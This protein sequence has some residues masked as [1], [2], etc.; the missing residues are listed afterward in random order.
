MSSNKMVFSFLTPGDTSHIPVPRDGC[1]NEVA[2]LSSKLV[3]MT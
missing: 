3:G 2:D 1:S